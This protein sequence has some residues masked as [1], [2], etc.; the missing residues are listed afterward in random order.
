MIKKR[1]DSL[2]II[3]GLMILWMIIYH[4]FIWANNTESNV[5]I[6]FIK[7]FYFFIPWFYFKSGFVCNN[8]Y[9]LKIVIQKGAS[10]LLIPMVIWTLIGYLLIIPELIIK[11]YPFWKIPIN[12]VYNLLVY[13]ETMGNAPLWFLLSL[14]LVSVTMKLMADLKLNLIIVITISLAFLGFFLQYANIKVPLGLINYPIGMFFALSGVIC[15]QLNMKHKITK[16]NLFLLAITIFMSLSFASYVDIHHNSIRF[17]FY[18]AYIINSLLAI[19][20]SIVIFGILKFKLLAWIGKKSLT[21]LVLHWPVFYIIEGLFKLIHIPR[22]GYFYILILSS[23]AIIFSGLTA[24]LIPDKYIGL[25]GT[26]IL[27]RGKLIF[28]KRV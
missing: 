6:F 11:G 15:N 5:Y 20:S 22:E 21:Y 27:E 12:P 26:G 16:M 13:G 19:N 3:S 24:K 10:Q 18:W 2:D 14:F 7:C 1:N 4:S 17:G 28:R 8:N 9:S 23:V 25:D